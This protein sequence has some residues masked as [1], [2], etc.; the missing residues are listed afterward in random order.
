VATFA[1]ILVLSVIAARRG[2]T[3]D[4]EVY[5]EYFQ[6]LQGHPFEWS[7][8]DYWHMEI[9]FQLLTRA[10]GAI[11]ENTQIYFFIITAAGLI[12]LWRAAHLFAVPPFAALLYFGASLFP[13]LFLIQMRE[14][15][16]DC[17]GFC[18]VA[19]FARQRYLGSAVLLLFACTIHVS[20]ILIAAFV[21]GYIAVRKWDLPVIW[22][23]CAAAVI[24]LIGK[25]WLYSTSWSRVQYYLESP[26]YNEAASIFRLSTLKYVAIS[27]LGLLLLKRRTA[28]T[29]LLIMSCIAAV[30]IRI[31]F[32]DNYVFS[33]RFG[34]TLSIA[35]IFL[36]PCLADRLGRIWLWVGVPVA[37]IISAIYLLMIEHP[38]ILEL[39]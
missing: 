23:I 30:V 5:R 28:A 9:G 19:Y 25:K 21:V 35:E 8:F 7:Y 38:H 31:V 24:L 4:T 11:T 6:N 34:A 39:Y 17:L 26:E 1:L 12:C 20:A 15:F 27:C 2:Q 13:L 18:G 36:L 3:Y 22:T 16:A 29:N 33:G 32:A 14:G 10:I 37:C